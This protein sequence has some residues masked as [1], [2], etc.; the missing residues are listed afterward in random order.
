MKNENEKKDRYSIQKDIPSNQR[1]VLGRED[2]T[3][4]E[5]HAP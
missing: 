4:L 2:V 5:P 1:E 3:L